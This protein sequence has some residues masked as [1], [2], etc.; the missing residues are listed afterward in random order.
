MGT[1]VR[2]NALGRYF[3]M[4][5]LAVGLG[6]I[7]SQEAWAHART[8][9]FSQE[10]QTLPQ[11][12][13]EV[14]SHT[15]VK[16]PDMGKHSGENSWAF[17]E[18]LEYGVTDHL[19]IA[20][21]QQWERSN[22]EGLDDDG[23]AN[24]DTARYAGFK[25]EAKYRIGEKGK[26]WVDPLV[27]FEYEYEPQERFDGAAHGLESKIVLSKDFGKFNVTYNQIMDSKLGHKGR[28][29]HEYTLGANYE[30]FEGFRAGLEVAGQYWNPSV[31]RNEI[32]LGPTLAYEAKYFW[33]AAGVLIGANNIADDF[34]GRV[35]FGIPIG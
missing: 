25:F 7:A 29:E 10:Y 19:N 31:N 14:E 20:H 24:K 18:E 2:W 34:Q 30:V 26:Y 8:Y 17:E 6:G 27:Y 21:Y 13:F 32:G 5:L 9:V 22:H 11:G 1:R 35:S 4:L 15:K 33:V 28:T 12:M 3:G 16:V 23:V